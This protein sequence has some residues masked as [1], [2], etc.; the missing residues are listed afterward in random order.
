VA[1]MLSIK[2]KNSERDRLKIEITNVDG[3]TV[4][5]KTNFVNENTVELQIDMTSWKAQIYVLRVSNSKGE[6]IATKK[7]IKL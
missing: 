7:L 1:D 2:L 6:L 3:K 4:Y 5:N